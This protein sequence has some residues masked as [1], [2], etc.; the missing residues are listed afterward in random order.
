MPLFE[1]IKLS[2]V[3]PPTESQPLGR[4]R[5]RLVR[6]LERQL[7]L[8]TAKAAGRTIQLTRKRRIKNEATGRAELKDEPIDVAPWWWQGAGGVIYLTIRAGGRTLQ[9]APGKSAIEVGAIDDLPKK[10][11]DILDAVRA[12]ELD[13]F[14]A[15]IN[16]RERALTPIVTTAAAQNATAKK[17]AEKR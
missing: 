9:L 16:A 6:A 4:F 11:A 8:A 2:D 7:A 5:R 14:A 10:L 13:K 12:G 3:A 17:A 15:A 1:T